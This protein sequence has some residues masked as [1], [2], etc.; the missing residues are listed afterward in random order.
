[1]GK[2]KSYKDYQD[3]LEYHQ[4]ERSISQRRDR[5]QQEKYK[6]KQYVAPSERYKRVV[7]DQR[8]TNP[9][10]CPQ[11]GRQMK[12]IKINNQ[13]AYYICKQDDIRAYLQIKNGKVMIKGAPADRKT[14]WLRREIH[15]CFELIVNNQYMSYETLTQYLTMH[16]YGHAEPD[17]H[18]GS[19]DEQQCKNILSELERLL[20]ECGI[21]HTIEYNPHN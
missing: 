5:G 9:L 11:C 4:K 15:V 13:P 3:T 16:L 1:M 8:V 7:A 2:K 18:V 10:I 12:L 14:R 6:K 19:L 17:F 20:K 21:E